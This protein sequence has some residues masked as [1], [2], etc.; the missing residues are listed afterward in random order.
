MRYQV[1]KNYFF[2]P[3]VLLVS[4]FVVSCK[5]KLSHNGKSSTENKPVSQEQQ[6]GEAADGKYKLALHPKAGA[7]YY[8]AIS[9][10]TKMELDA[11]GKKIVKGNISDI[12]LVYQITQVSKDTIVIKAT[13]DKFH[14]VLENDGD[15]QEIDADSPPESRDAV[16][17]VL[18][19]IKGSFLMIIMTTGGRVLSVAGTKEI[20][21]KV[22]SG[23]GI[24]DDANTR[25]Q[26]KMQLQK[27]IGN[28]FIQNN[29]G[30][31][32]NLYPDNVVEEGHE[33]I[34]KNKQSGEI[35][36]ESVAKC[37]LASIDEEEA[38]IETRAELN[39]H[40]SPSD[41]AGQQV[42]TDLKGS[43]DGKLKVD[44]ATGM[45][46]YAKSKATLEG[47]IQVM[48]NVVP[49]EINITKTVSVTPE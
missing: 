29:L 27:L 6:D 47:T 33:W 39:T 31:V 5:G 2:Y 10:E 9:N 25:A 21:N 42:S 45:P 11:N 15:K 36:F 37:K 28:D 22:L 14:I 49:V 13:Y 18:S 3:V 44:M 46:L 34:V 23:L 38:I 26:V 43:A 40:N 16:E 1:I 24:Y 41:I 7:K 19:N 4:L 32:F 17:R 20:E 12:G 30:Q 35:S 8:Y 48:A